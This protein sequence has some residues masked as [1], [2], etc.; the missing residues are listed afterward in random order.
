MQPSD[1]YHSR[2]SHGLLLARPPASLTRTVGPP[3][4]CSPA[5]PPLILPQLIS[6][7]SAQRRYP[8]AATA[9]SLVL[10]VGGAR[11]SRRRS[12]SHPPWASADC[13]ACWFGWASSLLGR[14]ARF[15]GRNE[16]IARF[17]TQNLFFAGGEHWN[18]KLFRED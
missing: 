4:S 2:G 16:R 17:V 10:P 11:S 15:A 5:G 6:A 12:S 8:P 1:P 3:P 9:P 14:I 7:S 13:F 18:P